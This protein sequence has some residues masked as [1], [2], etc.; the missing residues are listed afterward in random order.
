MKILGFKNSGLKLEFRNFSL[1]PRIPPAKD[2]LT[3]LNILIYSESIWYNLAV[4]VKIFEAKNDDKLTL[5]MPFN[6]L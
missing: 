6:V 2:L 5:E 3:N 1:F 4:I